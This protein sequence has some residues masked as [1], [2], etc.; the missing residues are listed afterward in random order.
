MALRDKKSQFAQKA[1]FNNTL[2]AAFLISFG[3]CTVILPTLTSEEADIWA[4][5]SDIVYGITR[6]IFIANVVVAICLMLHL[7]YNKR[8]Y[9]QSQEIF[10]PLRCHHC[11]RVLVNQRDRASCTSP[12]NY[13][14]ESKTSEHSTTH[15]SE[16]ATLPPRPENPGTSVARRHFPK[17]EEAPG[18]LSISVS[19]GSL[20]DSHM[21][22]TL[23]MC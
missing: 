20:G 17:T 13:S 8:H 16:D 2:M 3:L 14:C 12:C 15:L 5:N 9:H 22:R 23:P 1:A 10:W 11:F 18:Y 21:G 6:L 7:I 19:D 4:S